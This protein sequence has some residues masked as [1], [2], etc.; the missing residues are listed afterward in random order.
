M[1]ED[2]MMNKERRS[3]QRGRLRVDLELES[4]LTFRGVTSDVAPGGMRVL[5]AEELP[6]GSLV[7]VGFNLPTKHIEAQAEVSWVVERRQERQPYWEMGIEFLDLDEDN[8]RA[9]ASYVA[10]V[11]VGSGTFRGG[12]P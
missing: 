2:E 12:D 1:L 11:V 8:R 10:A 6:V 4:I 5:V 9:I 3:D 7:D